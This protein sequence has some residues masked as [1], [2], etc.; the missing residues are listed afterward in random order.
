MG[1]VN[2]S[3]NA[4]FAVQQGDLLL[5][6]IVSGADVSLTAQ[7]SILKSAAAD[8]LAVN[9]AATGNL[10]LSAGTS[11]G[12]T[13]KTLDVDLG[14]QVTAQAGQDIYLNEAQGNFGGTLNVDQ[15]HA[16]NGTVSLEAYGSI[17]AVNAGDGVNGK[18]TAEVTANNVVL[19]SHTG[20]IGVVN[21][22]LDLDSSNPVLG[23][24]DAQAAQLVALNEISGDLRVGL[25][26]SQSSDVAI[27][28]HPHRFT[29]LP[30]IRLRTLSEIVSSSRHRILWARVPMIL[31]STPLSPVRVASWQVRT[32]ASM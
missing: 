5:G 21:A 18:T 25:I 32:T 7:R 2:T 31:R 3:G 12:S 15:V 13:T 24:V 19:L 28:R 17:L 30:T 9:V 27:S 26:T 6:S 20:G 14:G 16:L 4:T 1:V 29:T 8:P 22:P 23:E 11:I 10:T